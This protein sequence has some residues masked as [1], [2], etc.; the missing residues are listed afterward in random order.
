MQTSQR[1]SDRYLDV[2]KNSYSTPIPL[3]IIL[4]LNKIENGDF[5]WSFIMRGQPHR[6]IQPPA[7][8]Q[9]LCY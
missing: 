5:V 4:K 6:S 3:M 9:Q 1:F 8:I 2:A 7:F